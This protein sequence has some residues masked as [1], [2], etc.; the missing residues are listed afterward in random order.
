MNQPRAAAILGGLVLVLVWGLLPTSTPEPRRLPPRGAGDLKLHTN[1]IERVQ[2]GEPYYSAFGDE[3]RRGTYPAKSIF[4]WRTPAHYMFVAVLSPAFATILLKL[5]TLGAVL[6]TAAA[7]QRVG[8]LTAFLGTV[9]Q[10]GALATAFQPDAVAVAEIWAGVLIAISL[11]AYYSGYSGA[12]ALLGLG[13]LVC[14][15][16]AAPYCV[17]CLALAIQNRRRTEI[18]VWCAGLTL[19]GCYFGWH[20]MQVLAH[21]RPDDLAHEQYWLR[22]NGLRFVLATVAVNGWLGLLPRGAQ[23]VYVSG[24]LGGASAPSAAAQLRWSLVAYFLLFMIAGQPFNYY[25]GF[26]TAPMWAFGLAHAVD[27]IHRLVAS[28][29]AAPRSLG[30]PH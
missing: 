9:A 17:V 11:C 22:W 25:W 7:L 24:A 20:A 8:R 26:V 19:Y 30:V 5:L 27:G 13:A 15:E 10:M 6:L 4:N 23:A 28:V 16:L 12:A 3:L 14:R 29:S 21:Q 1:T 18:A 2:R